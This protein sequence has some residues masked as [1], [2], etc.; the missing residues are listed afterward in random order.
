MGHD[1]KKTSHFKHNTTYSIF[2]SGSNNMGSYKVTS[3]LYF[4][5]YI[6]S[7]ILVSGFKLMFKFTSQS[8]FDGACAELDNQSRNQ[9]LQSERLDA[10][11]GH[12]TKC[13]IYEKR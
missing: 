12:R 7:C 1:I 8:E 6:S 10:P 9:S 11:V 4:M 5:L 3:C 13:K 2:L